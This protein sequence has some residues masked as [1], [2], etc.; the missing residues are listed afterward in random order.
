MATSRKHLAVTAIAA[1]VS[2]IGLALVPVVASAA[3]TTP[4]TPSSPSTT[5]S[6]T[7]SA[8]Q[9]KIIKMQHDLE[10]VT[11][12]YNDAN[13]ALDKQKTAAGKAAG[14]YTA[15]K[16]SL[17]TEQK[18]VSKQ[19]ASAY[20]ADQ[21]AGL[22][23]IMSS[24]SPQEVLDKL[25]ALDRISTNKNLVLVK[26]AQAQQKAQTIKVAADK[27][28]AAAAMTAKDL[29]AKKAK[30]E[31][32]LAALKQQL[33]SLTA[34]QQAQVMTVSGGQAVQAPTVAV[35]QT[36]T[37]TGPVAGA[38]T[39]A[40]SAAVNAALSRQGMPYVWAAAGPSSFDCSGLTMWAYAQAGV[41]L[42]HSSS[43][44][45]SAGPSVGFGSLLPGDLVFMPG[46]V[47]MY[48][49]GGQ[50]VHAPTSGDVVKVVAFSSM[51]WSFANRPTG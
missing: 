14:E 21:M 33:N 3:P 51:S 40:A 8:V 50:V 34:T 27:A 25:N 39:A 36:P 1:I 44:Q 5:D 4:T 46:H 24:G 29:T 31:S 43:S 15:A 42:P 37:S 48:I 47:G 26:F 10:V 20:Q 41:G 38:P 6:A 7:L 16:K 49:G 17:A 11:E 23:T 9:Q 18:S 13:I 35:A 32:G 30:I 28:A 2:F 19:G 45:R 12:A 22:S